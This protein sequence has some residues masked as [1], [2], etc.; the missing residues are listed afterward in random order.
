MRDNITENWLKNNAGVTA[1]E[2]SLLAAPFMLI[3]IGIIELSMMYVANSMLLGGVDDV[4]REIRTGQLQNAPDQ[5][6]AF[7]DAFCQ[8]AGIFID[9]GKIQYQVETIDSFSAADMTMPK[10]DKDGKLVDKP[11]QPGAAS[12]LVLIRV[13]YFYQLMT[14]LIGKFFSNYPGN[15]RLM[16]ATVV[17]QNE[18]FTNQ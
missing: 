16:V 6:Q 9:C 4:A 14:P 13:V 10:F 5:Q 8:M 17:V 1:I 7:Q 2:F 15:Q 11:F 18:P 12:S 3:V